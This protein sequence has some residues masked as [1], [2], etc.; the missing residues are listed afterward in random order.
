MTFMSIYYFVIALFRTFALA[1][2]NKRL[3]SFIRTGCSAA[4]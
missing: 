2:E 1:K 3:I 4:R